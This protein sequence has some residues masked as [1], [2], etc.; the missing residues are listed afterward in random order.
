[1]IYFVTVITG[2]REL[3]TIGN[4]THFSVQRSVTKEKDRPNRN[5]LLS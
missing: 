5:G 4:T 3:L 1:M 2:K